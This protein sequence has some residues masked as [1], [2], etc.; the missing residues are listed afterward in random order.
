LLCNNSCEN[1]NAMIADWTSPK[2]LAFVIDLVRERKFTYGNI[3]PIN[4]ILNV[5]YNILYPVK[6]ASV[7]E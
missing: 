4:H 5:M 3:E 7:I 1:Y 6:I 2:N